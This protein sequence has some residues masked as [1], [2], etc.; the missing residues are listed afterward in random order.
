MVVHRTA[1]AFVWRTES[2]Q[3]FE[4]FSGSPRERLADG[5]LASRSFNFIADIL[6]FEQL[7]FDA[8]N[9]K[10]LG[11]V[12]IVVDRFGDLGF[13]IDRIVV[14]IHVTI[15]ARDSVVTPNVFGTCHFLTV[16]QRLVELFTMTSANDFDFIVGLKKFL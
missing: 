1:H 10:A 14:V 6:Q 15:V 11:V 12:R 13:C 5:R 4:S 9:I 8:F 16:Q 2:C 7:H 3:L